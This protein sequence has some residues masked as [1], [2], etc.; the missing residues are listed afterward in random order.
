MPKPKGRPPLP[1]DK[2]RGPAI[3]FRATPR[4]RAQ[5]ERAA[6]ENQRSL[7]REIESRLEASLLQDDFKTE[8]VK[9]NLIVVKSNA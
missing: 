3:Q 9:P 7:S 1:D 6:A 5:L 8:Y 2:K 4:I